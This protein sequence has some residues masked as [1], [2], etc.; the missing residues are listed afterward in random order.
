MKRIQRFVI[1]GLILAGLPSARLLAQTTSNYDP[2]ELFGPYF[3]TT[4]GNEYRSASGQPGP[5]YW[6][7]RADYQIAATLDPKAK[8]LT[9]EVTLDDSPGHDGAGDGSP[10]DHGARGD[11]SGRVISVTGRC[12]L[13]DHVTATVRLAPAGDR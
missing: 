6:Q 4:N 5:K 10:G 9:G 11:G 13:G 12:S 8:T 7:N 1:A 2:H 3:F